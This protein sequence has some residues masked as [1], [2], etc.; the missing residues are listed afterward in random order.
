MIFSPPEFAEV[1]FEFAKKVMTLLGFD[2]ST[3]EDGLIQGQLGKPT[4]VLGFQY[5]TTI[6]SG[7]PKVV[8]EVSQERIDA[9][10]KETSELVSMIKDG[11]RIM[12]KKIDRVLGLLSFICYAAE[13][14]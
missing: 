10:A 9:T 12:K 6:E 8:V 13:F 3:K 1:Y 11:R 4:E 2:L 14:R 7:K 5:T